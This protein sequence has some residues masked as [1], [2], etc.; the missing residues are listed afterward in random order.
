MLDTDGTQR[1]DV[2]W[3]ELDAQDWDRAMSE[4]PSCALQQDWN[5]GQAIIEQGHELRRAALIQCGK[6][7]AMAQIAQRRVL[8][9]LRM[10]LLMRGPVW[11]AD[12]NPEM[13]QGFINHIRHK[14]TGAVLMW[15]PEHSLDS[16][17]DE[18]K[19]CGH[20]RVLTGYS[21]VML[22]LSCGPDALMAA[23][24]GKWRN[25]VR[26]SLRAP[27]QVNSRPD[28]RLTDW[29]VTTNESYRRHVGYAGP[30]PEFVRAYGHKAGP[31][32][33]RVLI[34]TEAQQPVA[35]IALHIH[36]Q[37]ATYYLGCTTPRGRELRAHHLLLWC[38]IE[39]LCELGIQTLDLGG[40]DTQT[41]PGIARFK[42][43]AGGQPV[44]LPGTYLVPP[45][46]A[47]RANNAKGPRSPA[48]LRAI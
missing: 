9:P 39:L 19:R 8:G 32:K 13:E 44:T 16:G 24:H 17:S 46:F 25:L 47:A 28:R 31:G 40:I 11:L 34:A 42:L 18:A 20:H 4:A 5:Y 27:L 26:A 14:L 1:M 3:D 22:D 43:G 2:R 33:R 30:T 23:A 48:A 37:S 35:G 15:T 29:L 12:M 36:G 41:A 7:A 10:A 45:R 6:V 38:G 21:T